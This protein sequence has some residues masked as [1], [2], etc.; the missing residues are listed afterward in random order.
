M[1][2]CTVTPSED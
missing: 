1:A 2:V